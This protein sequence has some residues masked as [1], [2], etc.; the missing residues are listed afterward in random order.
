MVTTPT[1]HPFPSASSMLARWCFIDDKA[2]AHLKNLESRMVYC[3]PASVRSPRSPPRRL[4]QA[5]TDPT[6]SQG[7]TQAQNKASGDGGGA[8]CSDNPL[9]VSV[10]HLAWS[11][12]SEWRES[13]IC[14]G[15]VWMFCR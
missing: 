4:L 14:R 7:E 6:T 3:R 13:Q 11:T 9:C 12:L 1:T 15:E 5:H 10:R 2:A 8:H